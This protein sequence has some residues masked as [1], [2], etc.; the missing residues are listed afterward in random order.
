MKNAECVTEN[1]DV[2]EP[3]PIAGG[4]LKVAVASCGLGRVARGIET[5]A[6]DLAGALRSA[7]VSVTLFQGF[8]EPSAEWQR[9]VPCMF[10]FD[11]A[12]IRLVRR[13]RMVSGWRFGLGS[14]YGVEQTTFAWNLWPLI[15][16]SFDVLHVQDP[17]VA[18]VLDRLNRCGL[19]K[20]RVILAHGTEESVAYLRKLSNL[21]HLAPCYADDWRPHKPRRQRVFGIPNF[22][23]IDKFAPG[24]LRVVRQKWAMPQDALVVLSVAAIKK[25]HKRIDVLIREFDA[26][27]KLQKAPTVLVVAGGRE[28]DTDEVVHF[29]RE[30]L[31]ERF[32]PM[33]DVARCE[34]PGLY[35][36]ADIFALAS[37]R[38]MMPIALLEALSS[39][40][41]V[42]CNDTAVLRWIVSDA[43]N[44]NDIRVDG[45][46]AKQLVALADEDVRR[47]LSVAARRRAQEAFS[48][49]AVVRQVIGMYGDVLGLKNNLR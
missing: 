42:A 2:P 26:F 11:E 49:P 35:Q 48:A 4:A 43:G 32:I 33:V 37:D 6:A 40:L 34:M 44:L 47:G 5:W 41:P 38:E 10:R 13:L 3:W 36:A 21:Q 16:S 23:D 9:R 29:G 45:A 28:R 12:T 7:S 22:V 20:P 46:L 14:G 17:L 18:L 39:G 15:R 1:D 27:S 30:L 24:D 25:D 31:G 19:S 8:G